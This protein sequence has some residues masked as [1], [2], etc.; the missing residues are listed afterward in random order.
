MTGS[1]AFLSLDENAY[2]KTSVSLYVVS[3]AHGMRDSDEV[4]KKRVGT[5]S[6]ML[7]FNVVRILQGT[8]PSIKRRK[9]ERK[10]EGMKSE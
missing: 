9:K 6:S 8:P 7:L 2:T 4:A 3:R 5:H 1:R 10:K